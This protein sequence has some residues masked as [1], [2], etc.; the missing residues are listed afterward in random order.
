MEEVQTNPYILAATFANGI[1]LNT[2]VL[3]KKTLMWSPRIGFNYDLYGDRSLQIR[4]G[5]GIFTGNIP[6]VWIVSQSGDAGML[7][8]TLALNGQANTPG[9]FNPDPRAYLPATQPVPGSFVPS[10]TDALAPNFKFPQTWKSSLAMDTKLPWG[11]TF[12]LEAILN[13]DL[14]TPYFQNINLVAPAALNVSGYPDNRMIYPNANNQKYINPLKTTAV[15]ATSVIDPTGTSAFTAIQLTDG[16]KGMYFSLSAL[17][18]KQFN[19]G[20]SAFMSYTKTINSNLFDGSG[21]QPGSAW[22]ITPT[23]SLHG[24]NVAELS[25]A[26]YALPDKLNAGF[27]IRKEYFKHLATSLSLVYS[28]AIA[29]RFSY[30]YSGDFNRDG[31]NGNDLIY[32]PK[33]P[34]EITFVS[35]TYSNGVTYTPQQQSDLFFNYVSQDKYLSKHMG[36]YAERN[37]GQYPWSNEVDVRVLQD[38]FVNLGKY[39]NTIQFSLDIFNFGNLLNSN[40]GKAKSV[41]APSILTVTNISSY[42]PGGSTKPTFTLAQDPIK[43]GPVTQ[44]YRDVVGISSTYYMQFGLRYLFGN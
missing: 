39:R 36:Q 9:P 37:G 22:N 31:V 28:G 20:F 4:G 40:W 26:S 15:P 3:P 44:T 5:T 35:K 24:T 29:G 21:D 19:K 23:N 8:T 30:T 34:S 38:V 6:F 12:T 33:N 10:S 32:I 43:G 13:K 18:Q 1:K 7:Q 27:T 14:R 11:S 25:Y 2:G 41:N 17:L 16:T 42:S